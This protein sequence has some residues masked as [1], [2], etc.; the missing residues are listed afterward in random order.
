M[1]SHQTRDVLV[2]TRVSIVLAAFVL[3]SVAGCKKAPAAEQTAAAQTPLPAEGSAPQPPAPPKPMPAELPDVLAR[4]NGQPVTKFDFDRLVKNVE[5]RNGPVPAERRDEILR[6]ALDQLITYTV[7]KQEAA[8]RGITV[9]DADIEAQVARLQGTFPD[10]AEF[11]KA[12]AARQ[13]TVEQLRA[14][15]R[16]DMVIKKMV[17]AEVASLPP[18][19]EAEAKEFYDKNPDQFTQGEAVRASHILIAADEKADEAT[20][21]AARAK[22]DALLKR[23]KA[24]EDFA[25]LAKESSD[26]GSREQGGDLGYFQRGRMVPPFD[27]AAFNLKPGEISDVVTTQFGYHIIKLAERKPATTVP[28]EKVKDKVVEYLS[29]RKKQERADA[30]IAEAKKKAKIEV[31]V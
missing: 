21:Q 30:F 5:A 11:K 7:M 17:D 16:V 31:L 29:N 19:T 9:T 18:A 26:D 25:K 12:L 14:D 15:A 13:T 23:A 8:S 27:E 24:G 22:V 28:F 4:V 2:K 20:K 3:S 1:T 6:A 10:E